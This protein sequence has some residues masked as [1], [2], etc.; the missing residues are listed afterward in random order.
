MLW[1]HARHFE[2]VEDATTL[3]RDDAP[4]DGACPVAY[5]GHERMRDEVI[6]CGDRNLPKIGS[7]GVPFA[8]GDIPLYRSG[9]GA[10]VMREHR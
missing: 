6:G 9:R 3:A 1:G 4:G 10:S 5:A 2:I 7:R 8:D